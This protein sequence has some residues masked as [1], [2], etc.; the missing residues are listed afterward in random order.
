[1]AI[2]WTYPGQGVQYPQ[3]LHEVLAY[4]KQWGDDLHLIAQDT[5]VEAS[6][7]LSVDALS[8]DSHTA[9]R[10]TRS[11]Q[12]CLLISGVISA[13]M[14]QAKQVQPDYVAGLS[15]GAWTAATVAGVISF[16][17]AL[18]LVAKRGD[19][20]QY[21]YPSGYGMTALIGVTRHQVAG[22]LHE[23]IHQNPYNA[24]VFIA[25]INTATQIVIS[26]KSSTLQDFIDFIRVSN[27]RVQLAA[28]PL[29]V[30]VPSHC[31]LL[32]AAAHQLN[33][34][35]DNYQF[36]S[37]KYRYLSGTT[38]RLVTDATHIRDD[39]MFN[40]SRTIDW[41]SVVGSMWERG[42]RTQ[43]EAFSGSSLTGLAR[44]IFQQGNLLSFQ[45]TRFDSLVLSHS[46]N[47]DLY[48]EVL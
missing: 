15:I 17:D 46:L 33:E 47:R 37:P 25:N 4:T 45:N 6:D 39:L 2:V 14:L 12:L 38:A 16:A 26:G 40:M 3:M 41:E 22:W 13:R 23:F 43:I 9:L 44:H 36:S 18:N 1:M 34:V 42:I 19:L 20:M 35:A 31:D 21:A 27:E 8:L 5:L 48:K 7:V 29:N 10:S 24:E 32:G 28:K 11:V 30:S